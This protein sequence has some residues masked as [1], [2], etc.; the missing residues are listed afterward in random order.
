MNFDNFPELMLQKVTN[1]FNW[2]CVRDSAYKDLSLYEGFFDA[3]RLLVD[4]DLFLGKYLLKFGWG[5]HH[6]G[7][8]F[9]FFLAQD[10][11]L[12]AKIALWKCFDDESF[13]FLLWE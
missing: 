11:V 3:D 7:L 13:D 2:D 5:D 10:H 8:V 1:L 9:A 4:D 6:K 12:R